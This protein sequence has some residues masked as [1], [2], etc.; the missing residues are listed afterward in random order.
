L[1]S[2]YIWKEWEPTRKLIGKYEWYT[3]LKSGQIIFP[4]E[5][6]EGERSLFLPNIIEQNVYRFRN[7]KTGRMNSRTFPKNKTTRSE[8]VSELAYK[9]IDDGNVLIFTS[10]PNWAESIGDAMLRLLK[11]KEISSS[12]IK[13][14]FRYRSDLESIEIAEKWLG[15]NHTI[16]KCLKRGIGIH[17]GPLSEPIRKSIEKD[18]KEKKLEVLISTNTIG[19]GLNFPM[20]TAIIHSL[21]IDS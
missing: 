1:F 21:E 9:F 12:D 13:S 6:I 11:Y 15:T 8:A 20:K 19:Q 4:Y 5:K 16:T 7:P 10:K 17:Y 2:K 3:L 14:N 18:F